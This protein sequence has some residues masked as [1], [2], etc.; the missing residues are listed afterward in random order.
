MKKVSIIIP[1]YNG[2]EYIE[3]CLLSIFNQTCDNYEIIVV[4]DNSSDNSINIL[5][6]YIDRI[7]LF[8]LSKPAPCAVRNYG[9]SKCNGD[10]LLFLDM[11]DTLD[12]NLLEEINRYDKLDNISYP[13]KDIFF[14]YISKR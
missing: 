14:K 2:E 4:D 9:L 5:E 1:V 13:N 3:K 7:K 12:S 6:K 10:R 8:R 11:D